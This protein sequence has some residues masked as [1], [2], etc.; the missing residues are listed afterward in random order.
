MAY[1]SVDLSKQNPFPEKNN[2][3]ENILWN[4]WRIKTWTIVEFVGE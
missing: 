2:N 3:K 4:L 1:Y